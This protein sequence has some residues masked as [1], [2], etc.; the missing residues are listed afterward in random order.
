MQL[1]RAPLAGGEPELVA[2]AP[3]PASWAVT[4]VLDETYAWFTVPE[5]GLARVALGGGEP[6]VHRFT[7]A[8]GC[9]LQLTADADALY[10]TSNNGVYRLAKADF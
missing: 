6:E 5:C 1:M 8:Q 3:S 9:P 4:L 7:Q 10:F 2:H